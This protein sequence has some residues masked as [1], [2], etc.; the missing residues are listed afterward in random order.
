MTM[1]SKAPSLRLDWKAWDPVRRRSRA[2]AIDGQTFAMLRGLEE[3]KF[4]VTGPGQ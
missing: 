2:G 1:N 4:A 3:K